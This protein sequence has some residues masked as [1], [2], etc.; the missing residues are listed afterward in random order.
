MERWSKELG[1][2][3]T[4]AGG[5]LRNAYL[6]GMVFTFDIQD[7]KNK[8]ANDKDFVIDVWGN[9]INVNDKVKFPLDDM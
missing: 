4:M 3:Y 6:K 2:N 7:F 1:L 8:Y 5:C 9:E